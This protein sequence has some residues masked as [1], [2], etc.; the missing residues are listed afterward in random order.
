[1]P[2]YTTQ[3]EAIQDVRDWLGEERFNLIVDDL[4][5]CPNNGDL[6]LL[7]EALLLAFDAYQGIQGYPAVA[8]L[9]RYWS[10]YAK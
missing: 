9:E 6:E 8:M 2:K 1:M 3:D 5:N 7:E 4:R 10:G